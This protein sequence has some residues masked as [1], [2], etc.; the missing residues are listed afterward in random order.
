MPNH[1][2]S[3]S[4]DPIGDSQTVVK[5]QP[6]APEEGLYRR[7]LRTHL[8]RRSVLKFLGASVILIGVRTVVAS[9]AGYGL[10]GYG[11]T[12]YGGEK[13]NTDEIS[14][15]GDNSND[16]TRSVTVLEDFTLLRWY[17]NVRRE[18]RRVLRQQLSG[19]HS[20]QWRIGHRV[21]GTR[22]WSG[23][24]YRR[25]RLLYRRHRHIHPRRTDFYG[26]RRKIRSRGLQQHA[27]TTTVCD[28][29]WRFQRVR[30]EV[31]LKGDAQK[32]FFSTAGPPR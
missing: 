17:R 16:E 19:E 2:L 30:E 28:R 24:G 7:K 15:I 8:E 22:R 32:V 11:E 23:H 3:I 4:H 13:D 10:G 20:F 18:T 27:V 9:T 1:R 21:G 5:N 25:W 12:A 6:D 26:E 14:G 31:L 29:F